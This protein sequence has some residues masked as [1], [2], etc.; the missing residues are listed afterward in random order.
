MRFAVPVIPDDDALD[1]AEDAPAA[2]PPP[3]AE[4]AMSIDEAAALFR[5]R[6]VASAKLLQRSPPGTP[7]DLADA[8]ARDKA[9]LAC[10]AIPAAIRA[11]AWDLFRSNHDCKVLEHCP[12][13]P[14]PRGG[15]A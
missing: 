8:A 1:E 15:R 7:C 13:G 2:P 11:E 6:H 14:R 4:V 12:L 3:V 5:A 10:E 9:A